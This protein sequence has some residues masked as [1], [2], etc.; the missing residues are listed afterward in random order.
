MAFKVGFGHSPVCN[1]VELKD[2]ASVQFSLWL[3][4]RLHENW[5]FSPLDQF[6]MC[7]WKSRY[8]IS[9]PW[10]KNIKIHTH[11][12]KQIFKLYLCSS[13]KLGQPLWLCSRHLQ[14]IHLMLNFLSVSLASPGS[15][16]LDLPSYIY[17]ECKQ[18]LQHWPKLI[19]SW[20]N[21]KTL[22]S[23]YK[24]FDACQKQNKE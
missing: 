24:L 14:A 21:I 7:W 11:T 9:I 13:C 2:C 12:L 16:L 17:K 15:F 1:K 10:P 5:I 19:T 4:Y 20:V 18:F 22:I 23:R 8:I 6:W 3:L